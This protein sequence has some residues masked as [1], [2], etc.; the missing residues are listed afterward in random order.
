MKNVNNFQTAKV[1]PQGVVFSICLIFCQFQPGVADTSDAYKKSMCSF[2]KSKNIPE[3]VNWKI[4]ESFKRKQTVNILLFTFFKF[5]FHQ[6][7]QFETKMSGWV[8]QNLKSKRNRYV[9]EP[10]AELLSLK[11]F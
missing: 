10:L 2:L 4:S 6:K 11:L 8:V 5:Y 1:Q 9:T 3:V 7:K